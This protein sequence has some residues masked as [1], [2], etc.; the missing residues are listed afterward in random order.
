MEVRIFMRRQFVPIALTEIVVGCN[1]T[2][3]DADLGWC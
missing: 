2:D 3:V 1:A